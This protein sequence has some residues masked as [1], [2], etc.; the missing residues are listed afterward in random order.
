M[1]RSSGMDSDKGDVVAEESSRPFQVS[2]HPCFHTAP[3][4]RTWLGE[5]PLLTA[6]QKREACGSEVSKNKKRSRYVVVAQPRG[7]EMD[8]PVGLCPDLVARPALW[9]SSRFEGLSLPL[10]S[11]LSRRFSIPLLPSVF[12]G[13]L[14]ASASLCCPCHA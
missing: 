6:V 9:R 8:G 4:H 10:S 13:G 5:L 1:T 12:S 2:F 7:K 3:C 14:T 11:F